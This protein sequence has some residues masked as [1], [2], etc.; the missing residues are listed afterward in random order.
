[1][2]ARKY[3]YTHLGAV[4][5]SESFRDEFVAKIFFSSIRDAKQIAGIATKDPQTP[6]KSTLY[7]AIYNKYKID[8]INDRQSTIKTF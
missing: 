6:Y 4:I 5:G 8:I 2:H 1:M 3:G 7:M